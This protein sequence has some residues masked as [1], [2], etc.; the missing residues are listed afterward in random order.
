MF[1]TRFFEKFLQNQ[2]Y[3]SHVGHWGQGVGG[4]G[5]H[6]NNNSRKIS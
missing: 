1:E 4:G 6:L 5:I 2:R 3:D